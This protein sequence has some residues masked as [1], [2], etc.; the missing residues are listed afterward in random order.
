MSRVCLGQVACAGRADART[1]SLHDTSGV[2]SP[3]KKLLHQ[4]EADR[5][6]RERDRSGSLNTVAVING[7]Q[8]C[9]DLSRQIDNYDSLARQ[10]Q[11]PYMQDWI[12]QQRKAV[13][14]RQFELRCPECRSIRSVHVWYTDNGPGYSLRQELDTDTSSY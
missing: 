7:S 3:N 13:R 8:E 11:S 14:D 1:V 5:H 10:P 6:G 9:V 12:R 4:L 2:V